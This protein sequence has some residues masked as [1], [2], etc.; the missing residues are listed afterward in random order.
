MTQKE[1]SINKRN[2]ENYVSLGTDH[3]KTYRGRGLEST[4]KLFAQGKIK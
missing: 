1:K 3:L 4:K 2:S